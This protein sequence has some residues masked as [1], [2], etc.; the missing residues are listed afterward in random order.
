MHAWPALGRPRRYPCW[1][2]P[3]V[4]N[5]LDLHNRGAVV[6]ADPERGRT[7]AVIDEHAPD[8]GRTR[9][10][11]L[12]V[13]PGLDVEPRYPVVQHRAGPGRA[14][15]AVDRVIGRAPGRGHLPFLD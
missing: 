9:Q 1:Q 12:D 15:A 13:L 6:A 14:V 4:Q 11:V 3:S 7:R 2:E 8:V 10:L 5:R